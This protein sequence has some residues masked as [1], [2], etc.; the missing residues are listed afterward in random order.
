MSVVPMVPT[1]HEPAYRG[2]FGVESCSLGSV[3]SSQNQR[4]RDVV[5]KERAG[6][7]GEMAVT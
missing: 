2:G 3:W 7:T 5:A 6:N 1:I 4:K